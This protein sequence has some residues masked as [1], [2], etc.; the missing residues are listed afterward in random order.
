MQAPGF[1]DDQE[2]AASVSAEHASVARRLETF[3]SLESRHRRP[4]GARGAGRGGRVDRRRA[5]GAARV[6]R[7]PAR[8]ARGGA[9]VRGR[10]RR[11][12]RRRDRERRRRRHRLAGLGRD[13]AAH[14][15]ALGRAPRDE[16]GAEGGVRGGGGRHQVG[17]LHRARRERL[18]A[19]LRR[20]GRAPAGAH[21][22]RSTRS[23]AATR[24]SPAWRWRRWWRTRWRWRSSPT[25]SRSTPTA[26]QA[27]AAST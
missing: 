26:P 4:G 3:R 18:R 24:R 9:A 16:G 22:A 6:D 14:G 10:V 13:A 19:V 8:G 1:W 15:D 27:P 20:E 12:R 5:G 21:L 2:R 17:H 11:R 7:V 25:T 23:R